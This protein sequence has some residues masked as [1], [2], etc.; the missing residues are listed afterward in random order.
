VKSLVR[1]ALGAAAL[2]LCACPQGQSSRIPAG[3]KLLYDSTFSAPDQT[4]DAEVK[5]VEPTASDYIFPTKRPTGLFFGH[6]TVVASLCGMDQPAR[7][8]VATGTNGMEGIEFLFDPGFRTYH[9]EMDL[10][11]V[12]IA[13]P[14]IAAQ[15]IQVGLYFDVAAA[16]VLGFTSNFEVA[17]LDPNRDVDVR[18]I[19]VQIGNYK[20]GKPMRV[21]V[22]LDM[23]I[24]K[25]TWRIAID[26]K[27]LREQQITG[28]I[29]R[30]V[31]VVVRGNA[32]TVAAID[33]VL[34]WAEHE[35]KDPDEPP[36]QPEQ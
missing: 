18:E 22:D 11:V 16:H 9:V 25:Q 29:P 20:V 15:P 3:A 31:R 27:V 36:A 13:P 33:N 1:I 10:C 34:I 2:S 32:K 12:D 28:T 21:T 14:P 30:G 5:V 4:V 24:E 7:L 23:P 19:P 26:G 17:I 35:M 6:P 8:S